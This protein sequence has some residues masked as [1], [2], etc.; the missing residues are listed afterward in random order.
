MTRTVL[1]LIFTILAGLLV[2]FSLSADVLLIEEA[3]QSDDYSL[4]TRL[5]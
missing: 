2:P 5:Q 3:R 1:A 4:E